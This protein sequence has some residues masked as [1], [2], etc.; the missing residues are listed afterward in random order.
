[1]PRVMKPPVKAACLACRA[2]KTRCD[3]QHPC[4][5]C[6]GR[7]RECGYQ[8]SRRGGPRRGAQ[9]ERQRK[10]N[11][12]NSLP[13]SMS[14]VANEIEPFLDNMIG[15]AS[16][17]A[18]IHNLDLSPDSLSIVDEAQQIWGQLTPHDDRSFDSVPMHDRGSS[19]VRAYQSEAE[20]VNAYYIY[21]HPYLPLLPPPVAP[22][23]ED[24]HTVIGPFDEAS[25]AKK[26]RM[27]YWPTSSLTLALSAMLVLIP[28]PEDT[29]PM[30]ETSLALR[31]S[32][33]QLFA[34]AA[35][36]AVETE[37]DDLSPTLSTNVFEAESCR[38]RNGLHP[39]VPAQ[40]HPVMALVVLGIYEYC[41][42]GNISRMRARGNQAIT[43]AMDISLH[44]LDSTTTDY[45]EAQRRAWWMTIWV[46]YLSSNLHLSP[47]I[48]SMNDPRITTPYPKFDVYLEPWPMM[49]K[50]QEA[51]FESHKIVQNIERVDETAILSDFGT[52]IRKLDSNLVSL[53][54]EA[55]R[56]LLTTFDEE[57]EASVA[58]N[59]WMI[60][61]MFI[62]AARTRLHRFRAFMDI[63]LFLDKYCDLAAINSVDFPHQTSPPKWV[64]DCEI[65][66]PFTEQESS[67][68]CLK[69]S[70]VV[71]TIYRNL[72]YPNPLGPAPSSRSTTYPK[73]IPYFACSGIQSCYALLMLL[74]R[75]R[76]SI[77]TDRLADCY[78]LL[79]NPTP[80]SEI[81]DAERLREELR[82]G[83]E[84]LGR[85]LKSDVI[86]EGVGGMGREIE[87]A[88]LAAFP[89]CFEI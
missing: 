12:G 80:A 59:M 60:S 49:M 77:A 43:T 20:I 5:N 72:P 64:T 65:S 70:L 54:G 61:R 35:L 24:R 4:G 16:P 8:P 84:I 76:A 3:G 25:P 47:P 86:F 36:T 87:G 89:N 29:F 79:N 82:H 74:H 30:A 71:T 52:R 15:L 23:H 73:T 68:I 48:V 50:T 2:S 1:M 67:I 11:A 32:Y 21:I 22:Q 62:H 14:D 57:P 6:S 51:L 69:S 39:Q 17:Y 10:P 88:Y 55:D 9:Y 85:S 27:P 44:R 33:A 31:R 53:I 7:K 75:L 63:P 34:Q 45:S 42:R 40:L 81:A 58:Q 13:S 83:V 18:G 37:T 56:H 41:Q 38:T 46:S 66:F 26:S 78:H 19:A 28:T